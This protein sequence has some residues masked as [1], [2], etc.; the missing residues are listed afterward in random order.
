[1]VHS[2]IRE[3]FS[4]FFHA[5]RM[6]YSILI[7]SVRNDVDNKPNKITNGALILHNMMIRLEQDDA[8]GKEKRI[9]KQL[10]IVVTG[11]AK[12]AIENRKKQNGLRSDM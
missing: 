3:Q 7:F 1:M 6:R 2:N 8:I 11:R 9:G 12:Y 4:F 5:L 10:K